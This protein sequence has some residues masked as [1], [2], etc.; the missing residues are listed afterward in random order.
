MSFRKGF[1]IIKTSVKQGFRGIKAGGRDFDFK[2]RKM[3]YTDDKAL[4]KDIRQTAGQDGAG[5]VMVIPVDNLQEDRTRVH[6]YKF[7]L[8]HLGNWKDRIDWT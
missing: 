2:Q 6:N 3:Y 4:A 1:E 5:D 7:S 8:A